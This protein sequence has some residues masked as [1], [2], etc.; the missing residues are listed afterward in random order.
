MIKDLPIDPVLEKGY[1]VRLLRDDF[2]QIS[3]DW[4]H[5]SEVFRQSADA[6]LDCVYG[7][8]EKDKLDVFRCGLANAPLYVFIHGGYWQRGDKSIYSFIAAPFVEAGIDIA[9]VGY[10]LYPDISMTTMTNKIREAVV[11]LYRNAASL[12]VSADRINLSGHSAGA[13]LTAMGLTT[14]W[15]EFGDDLTPDLVKTGIPF[16]G[17]YHLEPLLQTT[18]SEALFLRESELKSLSPQY[19]EPSAIV[20]ILVILGGAESIEFF[21]QADLFIEKWSKLGVPMDKFI[22]P[23]VDHFDLLN[24]LA[25]PESQ[26]FQK[27]KSWL[28]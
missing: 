20:P 26:I 5:R 12:G 6:L 27:L 24:Q 13:H 1:N 19:L 28:E 7:D 22:E 17:I 2:T 11:W 16:S 21:W 10:E 15:S 23:G 14:C 18:I 9:V 25:K 4:M 8:G 3:A